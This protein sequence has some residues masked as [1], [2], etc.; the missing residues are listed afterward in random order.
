MFDLEYLIKIFPQILSRSYITLEIT[1]ISSIIAFL[2]G[3]LIAV[4][5]YNRVT[6]LY[7]IT[8]TFVSVIRGTPGVAQLYFF[9]YGL[10]V[11]SESVRNMTPLI[12]VSVVLSLNASAFMSES[13]R[14][15]LISVDEGQIEAAKS[16]GISSFNIFK[17]IIFPQA[18]RVAIPP[19]FNDLINLI[20]LSSLSFMIGVADIMGAAKIEGA[21]TFRYFEIY[22]VVMLVY[23]LIIMIFGAISKQIEKKIAREY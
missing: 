5:N 7:P 13:L 19:L 18:I 2:L 10:A 9:Y 11:F 1:F 6:F 12:A 15:G 14:G 22:A 4:V 8:K 16:L 3:S 20:K 23:W 21:K 17:R